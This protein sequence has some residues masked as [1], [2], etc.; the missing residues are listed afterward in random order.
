MY[1]WGG[2]GPLNSNSIICSMKNGTVGGYAYCTNH[3]IAWVGFRFRGAPG[4]MGIFVISFCQI[5]V[6]T[7]KSLTS[8]LGALST[9]PYSKSSPDYCI[10]YMKGLNESLR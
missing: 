2:Q 7:E 5:Y 4:T 1:D 6:K 9:V 8:E 3:V 10:I